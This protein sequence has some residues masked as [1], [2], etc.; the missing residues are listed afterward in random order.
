MTLRNIAERARQIVS[1]TLFADAEPELDRL[2]I[3]GAVISRDGDHYRIETGGE[4]WDDLATQAQRL[5]SLCDC[6]ALLSTHG[7][8]FHCRTCGR[9]FRRPV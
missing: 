9:E 3:S 2:L 7:D 5:E 6:G 4:E 1:E 8:H